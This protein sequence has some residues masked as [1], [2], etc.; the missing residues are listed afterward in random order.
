MDAFEVKIAKQTSLLQ[1]HTK[2]PPNTHQLSTSLIHVST[3]STFIISL[4]Q[5]S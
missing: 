4:F 5:K 1:A 3:S 2:D